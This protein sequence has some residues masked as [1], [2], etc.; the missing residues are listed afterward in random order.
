[1]VI[2]NV[3]LYSNT[4]CFANKTESIQSKLWYL[5]EERAEEPTESLDIII[6][7]SLKFK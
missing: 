7:C 1:M 6:I 3:Y 2:A 4:Y 5:Q